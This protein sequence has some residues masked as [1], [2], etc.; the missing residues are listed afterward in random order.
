MPP[1]SAH[2]QQHWSTRL[3][4]AS[5]IRALVRRYDG[6]QL[7]TLHPALTRVHKMFAMHGTKSPNFEARVEKYTN[8]K[9]FTLVPRPLSGP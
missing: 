1:A 9:G 4:L 5:C 7:R 2:V 3:L 8:Q 6:Q